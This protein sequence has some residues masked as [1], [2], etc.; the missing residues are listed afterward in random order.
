MRLK[1]KEKRL[2]I[3][4]LAEVKINGFALLD[5]LEARKI[6]QITRD[7]GVRENVFIAN[8]KKRQKS[9]FISLSNILDSISRG[10]KNTAY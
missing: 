10:R 1:T 2:L 6:G 4:V 9:I 3:P 5:P 7:L 8:D